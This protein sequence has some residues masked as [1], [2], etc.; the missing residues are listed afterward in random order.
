M[1]NVLFLG[2]GNY[3]SSNVNK[4]NHLFDDFNI[5]AMKLE[6]TKGGASVV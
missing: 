4:N 3:S 2:R 1:R 6:K 5:M